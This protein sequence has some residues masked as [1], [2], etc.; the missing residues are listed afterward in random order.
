MC[1][2]GAAVAEIVRDVDELERVEEGVGLAAV[3]EESAMIVPP[4]SI[5]D[6]ASAC[7]G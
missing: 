1:H 7:C 3:F 6:M 4:A 5:W 2:Q